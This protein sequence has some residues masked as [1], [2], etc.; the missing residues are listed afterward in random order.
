M[1]KTIDK[2]IK[3]SIAANKWKCGTKE[4]LQSIKSSKL[5]IFCDTLDAKSKLTMEQQAASS[6]V[7][8][9]HFGGNSVNLGKL[10]NKPF[11]I[12]AISLKSG[13]EEEIK[14]IVSEMA[15]DPT[16]SKV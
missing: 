8:I 15:K 16:K 12:S 13:T 7:P 14:S 6:N 10:C 4:V 2:V 9:Y 11:R 1:V 3:E 5:I